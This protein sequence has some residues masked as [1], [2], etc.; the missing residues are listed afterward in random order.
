MK[1]LSKNE[2]SQLKER[3]MSEALKLG[4]RDVRICKPE[5]A[6]RDR[7]AY[8]KW[9]EDSMHGEMQYMAKTESIRLHNI[10]AVLPGTKSVIVFVA[11]YYQKDE[12]EQFPKS[13]EIGKI[14]RYAW[15]R[16]YHFVFREKL[17][18]IVNLLQA[19]YPEE[20]FRAC[21]DSA[22][23][24][25]RY[26]AQKSGAGFIGKNTML[27]SWMAGS[28][29][30]LSEILTTLDIAEDNE[31][32]G[33]CGNCTRCIDACPTSALEPYKLDAKKCISY[34]TIEKKS[35]LT[36]A[37][38]SSTGEW[39]FGC[40]IC[41]E[42]CPYNKAPKLGIMA[43]ITGENRV[44]GSFLLDKLL[45]PVSNKDFSKAFPESP[46]LRPGKNRLQTLVRKKKD[47]KKK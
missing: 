34:L 12:S 16:D 15:G 37:E 42:V 41:Q 26:F 25:E 18:E 32:T 43:Q 39:I 20:Q 5:V 10:D 14:A 30:L 33:T 22:P 38:I 2:S 7:T 13:S 46:I 28:F 3:I 47:Q 9:I 17:S 21:S 36:E 29:T 40:D 27:I 35:E 4:F 11:S 44:T 23:I 31:I 24:L 1:F 6:E 8:R 45:E 19:M